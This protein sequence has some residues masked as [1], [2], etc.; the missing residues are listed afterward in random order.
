MTTV[1]IDGIATE[2]HETH[3]KELLM[4]ILK[5]LQS[6]ESQLA[7]TTGHCTLDSLEELLRRSFE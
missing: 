6:I 1:K 5:T 7:Y 4:E 3:E 2:I